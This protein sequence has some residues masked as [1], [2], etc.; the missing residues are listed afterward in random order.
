[1]FG[2]FFGNLR[3]LPLIKNAVE[4]AEWPSTAF[5]YIDLYFEVKTV[6]QRL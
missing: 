3:D 4:G 2:D 1:M 6:L 5:L